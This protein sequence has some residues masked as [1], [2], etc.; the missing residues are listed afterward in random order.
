[1]A[2][3]FEI[4]LTPDDGDTWSKILDTIPGTY[5]CGGEDVS[6]RIWCFYVHNSDTLRYIYSDDQG[7]S[8]SSPTTIVSGIEEASLGFRE[9]ETG[10]IWVSYWKDDKPYVIYTKDSG[11]TWETPILVE[12]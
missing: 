9:D 12:E 7:G 6:G 2:E 1:M 3:K 4:Y 10:R 11:A 5:P 8:F